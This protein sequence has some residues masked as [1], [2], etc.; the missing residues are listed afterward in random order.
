[1]VFLQAGILPARQPAILSFAPDGMIV[2]T[3]MST[4]C[5]AVVEAFAPATSGAWLTVHAGPPTGA[6]SRVQLTVTNTDARF[7]IVNA[8]HSNAPPNMVLIP[9]GS[10]RGM[11]PVGAGESHDLCSYPSSYS[12]SV[13]P[14]YMDRDEVTN[15][16]MA[17]VLQ[18]AY[19]HALV[20]A[21]AATVRNAQG[22]E[23]ELL[24]LDAAQCRLAWNGSTF[25]M[26]A[27]KGSGYP[28]VEVSWHGAVAFCNYRS[29]MEGRTACYDLSDWSCNFGADG[30][31]LPTAEEWELAARGGAAGKRFPSGGD[32]ISHGRANYY[33]FNWS[34]YDLSGGGFHP[35]YRSGG[36]PYTSPVGA[37]AANG[38]GLHDMAGNVSEWCNDWHPCYE[39]T[40]RVYRGGGWSG[41]A[42]AS[43]AGYLICFLPDGSYGFLGFRAVRPAGR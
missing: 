14:F 2:W 34:D 18:W 12:L 30:Y 32:T 40:N 21:T 6:L 42:D 31:R 28:C 26:K 22:D 17:E 1:M 36:Y 20:S 35:S 13:D 5:V 9:A 15:D 10:N 3:N 16:R 33:A 24:D 25:E 43:R 29:E 11:N 27:A 23:Q 8:D 37:F 7:R 19:D 38:Y 4:N 41:Y 39:G